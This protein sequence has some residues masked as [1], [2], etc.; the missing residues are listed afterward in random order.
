[1]TTTSNVNRLQSLFH[2]S[3]FIAHLAN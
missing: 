1:M 2:Y 3:D